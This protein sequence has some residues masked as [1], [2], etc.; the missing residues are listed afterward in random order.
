MVKS[1]SKY[2]IPVC[3]ILFIL[4]ASALAIETF[5]IFPKGGV[6]LDDGEMRWGRI[7]L[8]P[9]FAF[10]TT[11]NDNVFRG[12]DKTFVNGSFETR[13]D[14]V[15]FSNRPSLGIELQRG[16][17]E[18]FGFYFDY[19]GQ[20]Q[21]FRKLSQLNAFNHDISGGV[22]LGGPGGRADITIGGRYS[23]FNNLSSTS[24]ASPAVGGGEVP[25]GS[26]GDTDLRS[27]V[28]TRTNNKAVEGYMDAIYALSKIFKLKFRGD[29]RRRTLQGPSSGQNNIV[30]NLGGSFFWQAT[31]IV[32]YG[33]KYNHRMRKFDTIA[34][35]T[36]D[37]SDTDQVF[38]A[39]KWKPSKLIF[40]DLSVGLNSKRFDHSSGEDRN[41]FLFQIYVDYHPVKRTQVTM[42]AYREVFDSSFQTIQSYVLT[43]VQAALVQNMGKK[44][45][46][47]FSGSLQNRD[48]K[49]TLVD[50]KGGGVVRARVDNRFTGSVAL[51]YEIQKWLQAS[52]RYQYRQVF[53][54]FDDKDYTANI[55]ILE[56]AAKY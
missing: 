35:T 28:G 48:Y 31:P 23:K 10:R 45:K 44:L 3:L 56:I 40:A 8:H 6:K 32:A 54:T 22:N 55:G 47:D 1:F 14:D 9:G 36:N 24:L 30:Y 39:M 29:V 26:L 38:L 49:R 11:Y 41:D 27:N 34:V 5:E 20:D 2:L 21:H 12:A 18:V 13:E 15:Y 19:E 50:V 42:R 25:V 17:G 43:S 16:P 33:V 4:P 7:L 52:A 53:S 46:L 37:N 51:I